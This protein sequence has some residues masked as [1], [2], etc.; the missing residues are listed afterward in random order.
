MTHAPSQHVYHAL[1]SPYCKPMC[2]FCVNTNLYVCTDVT[3]KVTIIK[4][5]LDFNKKNTRD[6]MTPI[7]TVYALSDATL[8]NEE[9]MAEVGYTRVHT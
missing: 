2:F 3:V 4:G 6:I 9:T 5:A 8:L 7:K 1:P